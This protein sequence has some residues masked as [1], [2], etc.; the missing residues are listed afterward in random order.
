MKQS[1]IPVSRIF[2]GLLVLAYALVSLYPLI[3]MVI[4]SFK[5]DLSFFLNQYALPEIWRWENYAKAWTEANVSQYYFNS[6]VVTFS[7]LV[8]GIVVCS[9]AGYAMAKLKFRGK[10]LLLMITLCVLFV[11]APLLAFPNYFIVRDL[12][13]LG[14]RWGLIGPYVC[15]MIPLSNLLMMNAFNAVPHELS[16]SARLDGCSE[17]GILLRIMMPLAKPTIATIAILNFMS[18]WNE[19]MWAIISLSDQS[20]YTLPIGIVDLGSKVFIYGYGPVFAG[21]VLMTLPVVL[22]YVLMQKQFV[23]AITAG[24]VKG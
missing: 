16:E 11:P 24:A 4:Q 1:K 23:A 14:T 18:T 3:W 13:I 17:M 6:I 7:T 8:I 15:G 10:V 20:I 12:G 19:Y 5:D 9:L 21:M 22:F 2:F